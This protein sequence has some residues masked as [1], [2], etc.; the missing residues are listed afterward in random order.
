MG[1][2]APWG[3]SALGG[4]K[5]GLHLKSLKVFSEVKNF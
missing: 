3:Q 4:G 2:V 5:L 1:T